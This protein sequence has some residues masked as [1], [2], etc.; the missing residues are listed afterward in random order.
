MGEIGPSV[1]ETLQFLWKRNTLQLPS[2]VLWI[3]YLISH[4]V[5]QPRNLPGVTIHTIGWGLASV[6]GF[7]GFTDST[8]LSKS[9]TPLRASDK[10][11]TKT[12]ARTTEGRNKQTT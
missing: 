1:G 2:P 5:H 12:R 3:E 10:M 6:V 9:G 11:H 8:L 7:T 4:L